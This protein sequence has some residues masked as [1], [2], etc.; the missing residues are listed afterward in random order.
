MPALALLV[1]SLALAAAPPACT[2]SQL[3][4]HVGPAN[5]TAGTT[6]YPLTFINHSA[7]PCTLRGFPGVSSVTRRHRRI[8][9]PAARD[10]GFPVRTVRLRANG[11][12]ATAVFG[13]VD[14]GVFPPARC[15]PKSAWGLKVFAPGQT[16]A[17]FAH[18]RHE[19][20]SKPGAGDS[21]IRPVVR[22]RTGV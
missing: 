21:S 16:R 19:A 18:K 17:F 9:S 7:H 13:Q 6:F 22:G 2:H 8:G 4:L 20:C 5:G 11:G 15:H 14:P 3:R 1:S 12:A 10:H